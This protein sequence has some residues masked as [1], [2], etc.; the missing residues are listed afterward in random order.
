VMSQ[1]SIAATLAGGVSARLG[2]AR[3][4][5][6]A[7]VEKRL[8]FVDP[9]QRTISLAKLRPTQECSEGVQTAATFEDLSNAIVLHDVLV[10]VIKN[11]V[12]ARADASGGV[13]ALGEAEAAVFAEC[14]QESDGQVPL[15]YKAVPLRKLLSVEPAGIAHDRG[16]QDTSRARDTTVSRA[17][18]GAN[19]SLDQARVSLRK[20]ERAAAVKKA[21]LLLE[22]GM[23]DEA[24]FAIK[25]QLGDS[26]DEVERYLGRPREEYRY[27]SLSSFHYCT[28]RLWD[29]YGHHVVLVMDHDHL[30]AIEAFKDI[31][32]VGCGEDIRPPHWNAYERG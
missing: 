26:R 3:G 13:V 4:V 25:V 31:A 15:G 10:A 11:T 24:L 16:S 27:G 22:H 32:W 20:G 29:V 8:S 19:V 17:P 30:V 5:A 18:I 23:H 1:S 12:C 6:S 28:S 21:S 7:G 2:V 14:V 9:E